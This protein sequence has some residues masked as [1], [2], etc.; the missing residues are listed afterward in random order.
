MFMN[1][2]R[3]KSFPKL[4]LSSGSPNR[5]LYSSWHRESYATALLD[6]SSSFRENVEN[7]ILSTL[8]NMTRSN[9][10]VT[11]GDVMNFFQFEFWTT[12]PLEDSLP[13]SSNSKPLLSPS[14]DDLR[15]L[16]AGVREGGTK[17]R[18]RVKI[19]NDCLSVINK[20]FPTIPSRKRSRLDTLSNDGSNAL[21]STDRSSSGMGISKM[22]SQSHASTS[23]FELEQQRSEERT[24]NSIPNKRTRTS[25]VDPRAN[26]PARSTGV[27]DKDREVLR[28]PNSGVINGEDRTS[29]LTVD[30]WEKSK[31]KKRRSGIKTDGTASSMVMKSADGYR[32]SKQVIQPQLLTDAQFKDEPGI[33]NGSV[34]VGK[35]ESSLQQTGFGTLPICKAEQDN[36]PLHE[37]RERPI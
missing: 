19:F 9:S 7:Q 3:L 36:S 5:P 26:T 12:I 37:R 10:S 21:L 20:C 4:D 18:E 25:M 35:A 14:S 24:K 8:P 16:K 29:S 31:M 15:Q 2:L 27:M 13:G 23:S 30:G 33:A 34:G 32:E 17:A 28:Y 11:H 1:G 22:G 6:R